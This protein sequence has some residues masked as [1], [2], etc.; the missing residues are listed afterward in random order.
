MILVQSLAVKTG[1]LRAS[2]EGKL[3]T[4]FVSYGQIATLL[5]RD[6]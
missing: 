5:V 1:E 6:L 4:I 3:R 2:I